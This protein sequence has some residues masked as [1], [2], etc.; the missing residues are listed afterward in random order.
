MTY[1]HEIS[2]KNELGKVG[3][4]LDPNEIQSYEQSSSKEHLD[5]VNIVG[6]AKAYTDLVFF[7]WYVTFNKKKTYWAL[8][9]YIGCLSWYFGFNAESVG[10]VL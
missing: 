6:C 2:G 4:G 9:G 1:F 10:P 7:I 8:E 3:L 5:A